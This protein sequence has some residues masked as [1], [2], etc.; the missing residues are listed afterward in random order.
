MKTKNKFIILLI[1]LGILVIIFI[2][3]PN[4]L[5]KSSDNC[6]NPYELKDF[7]SGKE[8]ARICNDT[9]LID[10][11]KVVSK[12]EFPDLFEFKLDKDSKP[13]KV[14][15]YVRI[16]EKDKQEYVSLKSYI[17]YG[18]WNN[19]AIGI[20]RKEGNKFTLIFKKTFN[21][22]LGRWVNIEFGEDSTGRD[23]L[24]YINYHGEG[25]SVSGDIGYLGCYGACRLLWWDFYDWDSGKKTFVLANNKH[26]DEFKRLL[27]DYKERD[28]TTCMNEANVSES[29]T[30]LY[31]IRKNKEI[32]CSDNA[33]QPYTT[34]K[35]A[36]ILLKG[37][38][39]IE[40]IIGGQN[41]S[42]SQ[43]DK[44]KID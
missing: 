23:P 21:E 38:K 25:I 26:V 30:N 29:I 34:P 4:I 36:E 12:K 19:S 39:A 15:Q 24:Y 1:S 10:S 9:L 22:N 35:Q 13:D 33:V 40:L 11:K 3:Y 14:K 6:F 17:D 28:N 31:P 32:F 43:V 16:F 27:A 18:P 44:V 7:T 42:N 5:N 2:I 37:E 20:Y 41:I 8:V